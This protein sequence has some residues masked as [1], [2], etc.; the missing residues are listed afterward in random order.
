VDD[1]YELIYSLGIR[2]PVAIYDKISGEHEVL[3]KEGY[4][5]MCKNI[6]DIKKM[7]NW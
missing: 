4:N 2:T 3:D 7:F 6:N 5:K 1:R